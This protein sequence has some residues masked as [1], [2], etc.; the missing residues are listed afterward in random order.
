MKCPNC[1]N[2]KIGVYEAQGFTSIGSPIKECD[3]GYIWRL[4]PL[5]DGKQRIDVISAS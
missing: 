2:R 4:I 5:G 1:R 3:C